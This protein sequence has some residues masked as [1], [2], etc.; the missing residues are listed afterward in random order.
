[1]TFYY[2]RVPPSIWANS[3]TRQTSSPRCAS[4][5]SKQPSRAAVRSFWR[6]HL[7]QL[8]VWF[9][10]SSNTCLLA[11]ELET[12]STASRSRGPA[13]SSVISGFLDVQ[14]V[15]EVHL[16]RWCVQNWHCLAGI[17][18]AGYLLWPGTVHRAAALSRALPQALRAG[19]P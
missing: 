2:V 1:M 9:S 11:T 19:G 16:I 12:T 17:M 4:R 15:L 7:L 5:A 18:G 10:I 14:A 8:F 13:W 3:W 6:L